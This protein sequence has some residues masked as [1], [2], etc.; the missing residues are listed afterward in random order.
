MTITVTRPGMLSTF[1][2]LG[3]HGW[4]HLGVPVSGAMDVRA[5]RLANLLVGNDEDMATLEMTLTGATLQFGVN[6]CVAACGGDFAATRNGE[7]LPVN[8]PVVV[9]AGDRLAFGPSAHGARAYLSVHGGF[10]VPALLG[11][12]STFLRGGFGGLEGRAL[13]KGDHFGVRRPLA[14]AG[15][16]DLARQLWATRLYLSGPIA[17]PARTRVRIVP[18]H[19]W[20]G[21]TDDS[22]DALLT[23]PYRIQPES[24]RMGYRLAGPPLALAEPSELLSEATTFGTIQ[25]PGGGQPIVLMADRQTTGGYPKIAYVASCDLPLLAQMAPGRTLRFQLIDID[26]AR[27]LDLAIEAAFDAL[28]TQL[29]GVREALGNHAAATADAT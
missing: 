22:R 9:R 25:V 26:E 24:D 10:D 2:D 20:D 3:R 14:A 23:Q 27:E 16:E 29:A 13:R 18:S 17:E 11:S 6:A 1:Q 5:H 19:L 4:Q 12:Q 8:R 21:F 7:P 15:L 28:A